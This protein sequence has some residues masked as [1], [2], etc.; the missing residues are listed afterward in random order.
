MFQKNMKLPPAR[1]LEVEQ[2]SSIHI[3][4]CIHICTCMFSGQKNDL[5]NEKGQEMRKRE[6][7][8]QDPPTSRQLCKQLNFA[9]RAKQARKKWDAKTK[10]TSHPNPSGANLALLPNIECLPA[11]WTVPLCRSCRNVCQAH[12]L[13]VEPFT[14][15]VLPVS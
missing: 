12:T 2:R 6:N 4:L 9:E 8:K 1:Q 15:A 5:E 3:Y 14:F 11:V 13:E 7:A 10:Q